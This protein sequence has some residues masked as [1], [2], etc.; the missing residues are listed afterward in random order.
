VRVFDYIN[1][2]Q[3]REREREREREGVCARE[4]ER[5]TVREREINL[6]TD[7][8]KRHQSFESDI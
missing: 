8:K 6:F 7:M 5:V 3:E 4:K 2:R 1:E